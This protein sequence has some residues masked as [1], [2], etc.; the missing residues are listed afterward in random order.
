MV[1]AVVIAPVWNICTRPAAPRAS[2][3]KTKPMRAGAW[4]PGLEESV[5]AQQ[6]GFLPV[7][8]QHDHVTGRNPAGGDGPHDL[9]RGG[10]AGRVVG[11]AR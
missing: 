10:G 1:A 8:E 9:E 3:L 7:G 2:R 11:R 6:A 5:G 4:G